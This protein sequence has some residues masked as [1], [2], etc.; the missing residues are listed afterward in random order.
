MRRSKMIREYELLGSAILA[1][2]AP[3][4]ALIGAGVAAA[5]GLVAQYLAHQLSLRRERAAHQR[6]RLSRVVEEAALALHRDAQD[7]DAEPGP[8][9]TLAGTAPALVP[10]FDRASRGIALLHVHFGMTHP[11]IKQ[12]ADALVAVAEAER[13]FQEA[14]LK[15]DTSPSATG[16]V[17]KAIAEANLARETWT[18]SARYYVDYELGPGDRRD[19]RRITRDMNKRLW[20]SDASRSRLWRLRRKSRER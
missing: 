1:L 3:T 8:P 2:S 13:L 18:Q 11:L 4:A 14:L 12:Y 10:I 15:K 19:K 5:V 7:R 9:G 16:T 6:E 20:T 17:G